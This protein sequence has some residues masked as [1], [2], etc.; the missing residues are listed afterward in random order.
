MK[1]TKIII[2]LM[3]MF[4]FLI[5]AAQEDYTYNL[6]GI[7]K[8]DIETGARV[9][10]VTGTANEL[11]FTKYQRDSTNSEDDGYYDY[12]DEQDENDEDER[13]KGLKPVYSSGIDNTGF[14][15]SIKKEGDVLKIKDLKSYM[16]RGGMQIELPKDMDIKLDCGSMGSAKIKGFSS[17][18]EVKT[19]VG[20]IVLSDVTGPIT[21]YTSTGV[22]EVEFSTV[23]QSSPI[24][25]YS[26]T[27]LVDVA[28]PEDTK[29]DIE[30]RSSTGSV[31]TDFDIQPQR[32]DGMNV[33]G[34]SR[35]ISSKLNGGGVNIKLRSSTGNIYL[36]KK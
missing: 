35:K 29:A 23:N 4:C 19:S 36:R 24:S 31:F 18:I 14:G 5:M 27:G 7:K 20:K 11:R 25:I 32:K 2:N 9:K 10:I 17:E 12:N 15:M 33:V 16:E 26:S 13:S 34:S 1:R 21:A 22:I 30:L 6:D 28:L 8:V 3:A